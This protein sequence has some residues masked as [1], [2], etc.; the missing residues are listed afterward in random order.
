MATTP[1]TVITSAIT[2]EKM[3]RSMKKWE[4][5]GLLLRPGFDDLHGGAG[6]KARHAVGGDYVA[7]L[8]AAVDEPVVAVPGTDFDRADLRLHLLVHHDDD[9]ALGALEHRGLRHEYRV[10]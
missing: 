4:S 8:E 9:V 10:H 1:I 3:G 2:A 6:R 7:C 5:I